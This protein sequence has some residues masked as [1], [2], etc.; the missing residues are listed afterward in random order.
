VHLVDISGN[1]VDA[2]TADG[3]RLADGSEYAFDVLIFATGFD[4][5]TGTLNRIDIRGRGGQ[6]LRDKWADGPRTYLGMSTADFPNLFM[7]TGP[8]SPGV[9]SN[10]PTS[11]EQHVQFI[12][13]II[14]EMNERGVAMVEPTSAAEDG[15]VIHNEEVAAQTLFP[16]AD[17]TYTGA[18]I[19]GK[20][21]AF[22]PNLDTVVGYRALCDQV[23][24][25]DFNGFVFA[26]QRG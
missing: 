10:M 15:W 19:P 17:T 13:R 11:I 20:K 14:A 12:T 26:E 9:L 3:V 2:I 25:N 6:L 21:R 8:Q 22:L 5:T 7:I 23:V 24:E 1:P 18:N 4:A 16:Q